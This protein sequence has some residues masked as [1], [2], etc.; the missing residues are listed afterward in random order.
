MT[1]LTTSTS[2]RTTARLARLVGLAAV[3]A[4]VAGCGGGDDDAAGTTTTEAETTTTE[5]ETTTTTAAPRE[6]A[7]QATIDL[8]KAAT[9]QAADFPE[10]WKEFRA[11]Q[12]NEL[13]DASC[14]YVADGPEASL[15]NGAAQV[16]PIMQLRDVQGY[17]TSF[18]Y[19][20]PDEAAAKEWM[21]HVRSDD[22]ADCK[23]EA[24]QKFQDDNDGKTDISLESREIETLGEGGFE[25]YAQ[26]Y[27][28]D[29]DDN[30]TLA[31]D[32]FHYRL[33]RVVIE[34]QLERLSS[35]PE[36][37]WNAVGD[38]EH[39]AASAAYARIQSAEG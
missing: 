33:G 35:L 5:A 21:E 30:V 2:S 28:R 23:R 9:L 15:P 22:W 36:A 29:A 24:L 34:N 10:G 27:G 31:T 20:F 13:T 1:A 17:V 26:F 39:V 14:S 32:V 6:D 4:L 8:A 7:D 12:T 37:D 38:G 16:G 11:P 3:L 18:T 19:V 25:A